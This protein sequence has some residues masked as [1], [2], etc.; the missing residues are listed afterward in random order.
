MAV[1]RFN[2]VIDFLSR[3]CGGEVVTLYQDRGNTFLSRLCGGEVFGK[4][5][6]SSGA[7]LSRLCGG[8]ELT[9]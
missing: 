8:E 9:M 4:S 3:L 1:M 7:F 6:Q 2:C 5:C